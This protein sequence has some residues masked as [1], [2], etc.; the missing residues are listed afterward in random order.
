[1]TEPTGLHAEIWSF[2]VEQFAGMENASPRKAILPRFNVFK[3]K[4]ITDRDFRDA[5]SV[6]VNV[7]KKPICTS[8]STG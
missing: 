2:L 7:Y 4:E 1:M 3:H 8:P 5:I 6:L